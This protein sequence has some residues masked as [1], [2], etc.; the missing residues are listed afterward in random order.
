MFSRFQ[1][2]TQMYVHVYMDAMPIFES[3][4]KSQSIQKIGP[5]SAAH[6]YQPITETVYNQTH[7]W[8]WGIR[9]E[10]KQ[11]GCPS[12]GTLKKIGVVDLYWVKRGCEQSPTSCLF[13]DLGGE[14]RPCLNHFKLLKLPKSPELLDQLILF[15]LIKLVFGVQASIY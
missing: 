2:C 5:H 4:T 12:Y 8:P 11:R 10:L 6:S 14:K 3:V 1:L 15:S 7:L 9:V 13:L